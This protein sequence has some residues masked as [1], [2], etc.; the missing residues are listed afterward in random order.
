MHSLRVSRFACLTAF[1]IAAVL[2]ACAS[3]LKPHNGHTIVQQVDLQGY[4]GTWHQ[5]AHYDAWFQRKCV[6]NT[7][8]TYS[9]LPSGEV[10]VVNRCRNAA[11]TF[12][13]VTGVARP[14]GQATLAGT[15]LAP[16]SLQVS[17]VPPSLRWLPI[18]G[19][20]D[21]EF[22]DAAI[23]IAIISEPSHDYLWVL[24]RQPKLPADTLAVVKQQLATR[25]FDAAKVIWDPVD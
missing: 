8:A 1:A 18:W 7:T 21:L 6:R 17:F 25:G 11:G 20:Y 23:G 24:A 22:Y 4:A 14:R 3:T 15:R 16:A 19:D 2:T 13:E 5:V 12:D 9:L 10:Q